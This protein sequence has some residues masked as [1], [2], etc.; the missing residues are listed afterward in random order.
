[1]LAFESALLPTQQSVE[2]LQRFFELLDANAGALVVDAALVELF[3]HPACADAQFQT[4][5]GQHVDGRCVL[6]QHCGMT[7]SVGEYSGAQTDLVRRYGKRAERRDRSYL[8]TQVIRNHERVVTE[9]LGLLC[10]LDE[11]SRTTLFCVALATGCEPE[12]ARGIAAVGGTHISILLCI[13]QCLDTYADT[14]NSQLRQNLLGSHLRDSTVEDTP[15]PNNF[16]AKVN[17]NQ[18]SRLPGIHYPS[19]PDA[20]DHTCINCGEGT[21][22]RRFS[23]L[24]TVPSIES[25]SCR[26]DQLRMSCT[27]HAQDCCST[28][29]NAAPTTT[30][31]PG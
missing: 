27:S 4:T 16:S 23:P 8:V 15:E 17:P 6:R 19:L 3:L 24:P 7:E 20:L 18:T 5:T 2:N 14:R 25:P 28:R 11:A 1:M 22:R 30:S 29:P 10:E 26:S 13:G 12:F 21:G 9:F 31:C